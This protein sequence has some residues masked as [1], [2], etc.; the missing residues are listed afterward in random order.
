MVFV[1]DFQ[2]IDRPY[3]VVVGRLRD[4][5]SA[6]LADALGSARTEGEH[7]RARVGPPGWPDVL[8]KTVTVH[9]GPLRDRGDSVL[10]AFA[11]ESPHAGGLFP[12]L[13]ADLEV[14]P[15]GAAGVRVTLRA[16]YEPP[17]HR[18]GTAADQLLLHRVAEST[19]RAFL[20][21]LCRT[22]ESTTEGVG[23]TEREHS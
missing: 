4:D 14:A 10:L 3:N 7:L 22:L 15:F 1:Q 9:P 2:L 17:G 19:L 6:L 8:T 18:V 13:D 23:Q 16:R 5:P 11:W 12:R 21:R 20:V